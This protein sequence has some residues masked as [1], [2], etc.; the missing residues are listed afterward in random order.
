VITLNLT[1]GNDQGMYHSLQQEI[2]SEISSGCCTL[3]IGAGV[4][5]GAH[6]PG[7]GDLI[8]KLKDDLGCS[9]DHDFLTLAQAYER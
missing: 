2:A 4:S 9:S 8:E 3:F 1:Q 5:M 7:W 6:L